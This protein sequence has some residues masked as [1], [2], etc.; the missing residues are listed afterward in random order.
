MVAEEAFGALVGPFHRP[1]ELLRSQQQRAILRID[2][3]LHPEGAADVTGQH[4][5]L[6]RRHLEHV[7]GQCAADAHD[8]LATEMQRPAL[9]SRIVGAD[10]RTRLHGADGNAVGDDLE[11]GHVGCLGEGLLHRLSIAVVEVEHE[12]G[13]RLVV[14]LRRARLQRFVRRG[15][16]GQR[17]DVEFDRL[18]RILGLHGRLGH[19]AGHRFAN[20]AH[21]ADGER[22]PRRR[23]HRRAVAL[24]E[25]H[26]AAQWAE[27][28]RVEVGR[29]ED[30]EHAGHGEC[31]LDIDASEHAVR[32][33]AAHHHGMG[34]PR[35]IDV[36]R[37]AAL[38]A[39]EGWI[40]LARHR[41]ADAELHQRKAD[42]VEHVHARYSQSQKNCHPEPQA[43]DPSLRSG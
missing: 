2:L 24:R 40:F 29:G 26:R 1:A 11:A 28:S 22:R 15:D 3:R 37:I 34:L 25:V 6:V 8:A 38:A 21:L 36:V 32:D 17:F 43:K 10:R 13:G 5:D 30:G 7:L 18:R 35:E 39:Q 9:R 12:I 27:S 20:I 41:L 33:R 4:V 42:I 19:D 31:V 23:L 14:D 16:G